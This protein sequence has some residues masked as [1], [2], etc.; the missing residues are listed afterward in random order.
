MQKEWRIHRKKFLLST[1]P[2]EVKGTVFRENRMG[3][4]NWPT[5]NKLQILVL[6]YL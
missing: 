2:D 4:I 6:G 1:T 3:I 5:M